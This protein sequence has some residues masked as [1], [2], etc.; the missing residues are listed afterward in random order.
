MRY[1]YRCTVCKALLEY[2][3]PIQLRNEPV[4]CPSCGETATRAWAAELHSKQFRIPYSFRYANRSD[5]DHLPTTP[6]EK[7]SWKERAGID[8]DAVQI[9]LY[10][11]K[12]SE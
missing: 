1:L 8:V 7:R 4:Q 5:T 2:E 11:P 9:S 3:R 12:Q 10:S 6:E